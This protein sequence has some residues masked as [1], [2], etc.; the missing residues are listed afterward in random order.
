M[1]S[2]TDKRQET[3]ASA[4]GANV[5]PR[6]A[7]IFVV[8]PGGIRTGGPEGLHQLVHELRGFGADAHVSYYPF[9]QH[10]ETPA[11]YRGYDAAPA[12]PEDQP[13]SLVVV[14]EV[15][16]TLCEHY[17]HA[18]TAIWWLS[19][20]N[21]FRVEEHDATL[22]IR[23][24]ALMHSLGLR[25]APAHQPSL[26]RIRNKIH[27]AQSAYAMDFLQ[28]QRMSGSQLGDY[29]NPVFSKEAGDEPRERTILYNKAKPSKAFNDLLRDYPDL[30]WVP[31]AGMEREDVRT[32]CRRAMLYVDF[33][34]HPGRDRLP[35]EAAISGACV[36]TGRRG[37]AANDEDVSIPGAFKL[38]ENEAG[39]AARFRERVDFVM[40]DFTSA[41][42]QFKDYRTVIADDRRRFQN[43][44][45][46]AFFGA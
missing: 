31:I 41:Q 30:D 33:G 12:A 7:K 44:V 2:M 4:W 22:R 26:S 6:Y 14:P 45:R 38:D 19:V 40:S 20:D 23:I 16:A 1:L 24:R 5:V 8:C 11:A 37:A 21:F 9:D 10:F 29:L 25:D 28:K 46:D 3:D 32:A 27:F 18:A 36:I 42:D 13:G 17:K 43:N 34:Q 35:R 15:L 39:F